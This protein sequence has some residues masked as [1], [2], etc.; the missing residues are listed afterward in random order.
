VVT[1]GPSISSLGRAADSSPISSSDTSQS[2]PSS[3]TPTAAPCSESEPQRD[4]SQACTCTRETFGYSTHPRGPAEWIA[5]QQAVLARMCLLL[6]AALELT[7]RSLDS[8]ERRSG[9]L[10]LSDQSGC[11]L[12]TAP[13]SERAGDTSSSQSLWRVDTPGE[14]E[15]LPRLTSGLRM[16]GADGSC[17]PTPTASQGRRGWGLNVSGPKGRGRYAAHGETVRN[18]RRDISENGWRPEPLSHEW[19]MGWPRRWTLSVERA[20]SALATAKSRCKRRSPGD[21]SEGR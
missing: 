6:D 13:T 8:G 4:G 19:L 7:D 12:R 5:S 21:S 1:C 17:W 2:A 10:T 14:T 9:Q 3:G 11:S 18:V 15:A 20:L 16:F